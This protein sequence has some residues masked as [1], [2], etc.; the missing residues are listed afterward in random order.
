MQLPPSPAKNPDD[1]Y[2]FVHDT[3][4][5]CK[6]KVRY[7]QNDAEPN[8]PI[9]WSGTKE[10]FVS[11]LKLFY[12]AVKDA[13]PAAL[14]VVG[15]YDGLFNPPPFP[16]MSNQQAGLDFFNYVLKEGGDAFDI[17]DLRLYANAYTIPIRVK[18]MRE[19]MQSLGYNKPIICGEYGGP[20]FFGFPENRKYMPLLTSWMSLVSNPTQAANKDVA[21]PI[22]DLYQHMDTLA[23]QTQMFMQGCPAALDEKYQR[24]QCRELAMRNMLAFSAGAQKAL[25]WQLLDSS[26]RP[27]DNVMTLMYGK[28]GML[29]YQD[30]VLEKRYPVADAYELMAN[31]LAGIQSVKQIWIRDKPNIYLFEVDRGERGPLKVLWE[32]ETRSPEKTRLKLRSTWH[33]RPNEPLRWML[34]AKKCPCRYTTAVCKSEFR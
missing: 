21:T 16:P 6:G 13:D 7:W 23:P 8:D 19:Q 33:G 25:Y 30:G 2:R 9:F 28:V 26:T 32:S 17:F 18:Y 10:E 29:G 20:G 15:G 1:Y 22:A 3:V 11:E 5:H 12:K 24:I 31:A 27:R 4:A 34:W 14:V